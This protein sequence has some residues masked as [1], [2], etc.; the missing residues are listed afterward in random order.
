MSK[1]KI[2]YSVRYE[3]EVD[4]NSY[5][6]EWSKEGICDYEKSTGQAM[7]TL[8]FAVEEGK[9]TIEVEVEEFE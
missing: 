4:R 7:E 8:I 3:V 1:F 5:P 9:A 2:T 6:E